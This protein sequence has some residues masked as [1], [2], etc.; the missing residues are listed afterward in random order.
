M[1]LVLIYYRSASSQ[2]RDKKLLGRHSRPESSKWITGCL[3]AAEYEQVVTCSHACIPTSH[4]YDSNA[5][6]QTVIVR[7]GSGMLDLSGSHGT[8]NLVHARM[9]AA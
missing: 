9:I 6:F 7:A 5:E 2:A 4:Q 1:F 3:A 8:S